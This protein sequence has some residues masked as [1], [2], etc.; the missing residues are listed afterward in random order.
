MTVLYILLGLIA[1]VGVQQLAKAD[2]HS[3]RNLFIAGFSL[4]MGLSIPA[5]FSSLDAAASLNF[6]E[7]L[8][9]YRPTAEPMLG[10]LEANW[11]SGA[12][13]IVEAIGKNGMAVAAILGLLLDNLIPGTHAERG[14]HHPSTIAIAAGDETEEIESAG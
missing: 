3:D 10:W 12:R 4:F 6:G 8:A 11:G 1:A 5:Y 2:L 9:M 14:I 7:T 13:G